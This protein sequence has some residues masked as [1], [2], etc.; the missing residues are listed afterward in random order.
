MTPELLHA[1]EL[2][3]KWQYLEE[4]SVLVL[5]GKTIPES[6]ASRGFTH[7]WL[8]QATIVVVE[9]RR[10]GADPVAFFS[11]HPDEQPVGNRSAACMIHSIVMQILRLEPSM[12][13]EHEQ[14]LQSMVHAERW[15]TPGCERAAFSAA[16]RLL[17]EVLWM[18]REVKSLYLVVDRIELC[19][20]P[21]SRCLGEL[22]QLVVQAPM[23]VKA[24]VVVDSAQGNWNLDH[25]D[26]DILDHT[27]VKNHWDQR[28]PSAI[29]FDA[30]RFIM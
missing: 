16:C 7:S 4:S 21:L 11:F 25:L 13:R 6:R 30:G 28:R 20:T 17:N 27:I 10:E 24:L 26:E 29:E 12:L 15:D 19:D 3:Q 18:A 22:T 1:C 5:G 8:S 2:F 23:L 9:E 14:Q